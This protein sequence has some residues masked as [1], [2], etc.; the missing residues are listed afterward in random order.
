MQ[1]LEIIKK[2]VI[3][4]NTKTMDLILIFLKRLKNKYK[5]PEF[6]ELKRK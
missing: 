5:Q 1:N 6:V 4:N 3:K 2:L